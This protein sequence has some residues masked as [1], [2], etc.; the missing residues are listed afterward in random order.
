MRALV[1]TKARQLAPFKAIEAPFIPIE[2]PS[3]A[4]KRVGVVLANEPRAFPEASTSPALRFGRRGNG[5]LH[6][7]TGKVRANDG[8]DG[9]AGLR[10]VG[11]HL[12]QYWFEVN[13]KEQTR[14]FLSRINDG[15]KIWKLSPMDLESHRRWY[16][17]SRARDDM[18]QATDTSFAPWYIVNA[19][20]KRRAR[21]Y[22]R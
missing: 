11:D 19:D 14:R 17:Y 21:G 10:S 7:R 20:D 3:K 6:R 16:D 22:R 18:L 13:Q 9:G 5:L 2:K 8:A 4:L 1:Q 12:N 15:R